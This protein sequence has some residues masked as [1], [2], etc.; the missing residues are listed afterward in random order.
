VTLVTA[1]ELVALF[2][3]SFPAV[4]VLPARFGRFAG[5]HPPPDWLPELGHVDYQLAIGGLMHRLRTTAESFADPKA[6]LR[7]SDAARA[8]WARRPRGSGLA[9]GFCWASN[10]ALFRMDSSRRAVKKSMALE[11]LS[12]LADVAGVRLVSVLNWTIEPMP[13]AFAGKLEDLS[14]RLRSLDDTAALIETLDLVITVDTSVA[15]L[16]GAMG[17]PTWLLLHDFAD[18]RWGLTSARSYWY[19]DVRHFRQHEAGDW[20]RVVDE[21]A[22]ELAALAKARA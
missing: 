2:H 3:A 9:V 22:A 19:S 4:R 7:P 21:V 10:P 8:R 5:D 15:H 18:C 1:P 13:A 11:T 20:A 17:K 16:A 6:Y 12:P 14:T